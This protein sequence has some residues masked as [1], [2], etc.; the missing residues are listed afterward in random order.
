[1]GDLNLPKRDK[2][3]NIIKALEKKGLILPKHSTSMGSNLA[4]DKDYDQVCF[5]AGNMKKAY[6][7]NSGV[8][9]FDRKHFFSS[10][11]DVGPKYFNTVVKRHIADHRPL[12][13]EF[14]V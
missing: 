5:H 13:V 1:M 10:A 7:G 9:D 3:S 11:W 14:N 6:T 8:F 2:S 12:W 4:S